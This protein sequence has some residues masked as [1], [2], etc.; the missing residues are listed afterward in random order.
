MTKLYGIDVSH[1]QGNIDWDRVKEEGKTKFVMIRL[2]HG[3]N[4]GTL[5]REFKDNVHGAERVGIPWGAY[6]Y[7]YALNLT[8]VKQEAKYVIDVLKDYSP[9]YPIAFDMEDADGY[10]KNNGM[11]SNSQLVSMCVTFM[12]MLEKAGYYSIL[13]AGRSWLNSQLKSSKLDKYDKWLAD[14]YKDQSEYKGNYGMWQYTDKGRVAGISGL[15]D[16]NVAFIDYEKVIQPNKKPIVQ[17]KP[18]YINSYKVKLGDT[19][20]G[21]ATKHNTTIK[22]IMQLNPSIK[23]ANTIWANQVIK[24]PTRKK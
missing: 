6:F 5:D 22:R 7:S 9:D 13:Y 12:D 17:P 23:N 8:Q 1:H 3:S 24:I 16:M 21:I 20:S 14:W 19:L 11:P 15:V 2:G 18:E 10:K 4:G